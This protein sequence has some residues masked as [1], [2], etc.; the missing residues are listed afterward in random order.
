MRSVVIICHFFGKRFSYIAERLL[1]EG[2]EVKLLTSSFGH[3]TKLQ[4]SAPDKEYVSYFYE[5][6]YPTNVCPQRLISHHKAGKSLKEALSRIGRPELVYCGVPSLTVGNVASKW[7]HGQS[8]PFVIDVQDLWPEQFKMALNVPVV[9]DAIFA[10]LTYEANKLYKST[11]YIVAVSETYVKR[12]QQCSKAEGMCV[13]LGT[14]LSDFD[15]YASETKLSDSDGLIRIG[16]I[17]TMGTSYDLPTV[18]KAMAMVRQ[19]S[20]VDTQLIAMGDGPHKQ[21]FE[22]LATE[23]DVNAIFTGTLPYEEMVNQLSSCDI[24]INPFIKTAPHSI[25]NKVGD[26]A[27]AGL[28]V[29]NTLPTWEYRSVLEDYHAGISCESENIG[30]VADAIVK[31]ATSS[32]LRREM[33]F[34]NRRLAE[35]RFDKQK[36]YTALVT[37]LLD[38]AC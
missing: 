6:G 21:L 19:Q 18:I 15:K 1:D 29:I 13:Y 32:D 23:Y 14:V 7:A 24:A 11:D 34:G 8:I 5:T 38:L 27:A 36:T 37:K 31:L 22:R 9:S 2:C 26:Y 10:P 30:Q 17:G 33:G 3:K 35:E 25:V 12:A 20:G 4:K 16:Y 28:P